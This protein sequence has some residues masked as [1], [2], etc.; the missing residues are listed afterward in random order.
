MGQAARVS[1][2]AT[3][4][5]GRAGQV[6]PRPSPLTGGA[7][8]PGK[9]AKGCMLLR[10]RS[11]FD[12]HLVG[13]HIAMIIGNIFSPGVGCWRVNAALDRHHAVPPQPATFHRRDGRLR[14]ETVV[15]DRRPRRTGRR[16]PRAH[17]DQVR[18]GA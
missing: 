15:G 11:K 2:G 18:R 5:L 13:Y 8:R 14:H 12:N 7:V 1:G 17:E 10:V 16:R 3:S 6:Y 9:A 4:V